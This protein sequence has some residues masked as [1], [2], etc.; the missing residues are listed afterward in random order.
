MLMDALLVDWTFK[1]NESSLRSCIGFECLDPES[2][3]GKRVDMRNSV[4]HVILQLIFPG[5]RC[6]NDVY[7]FRLTQIFLYFE[8]YYFK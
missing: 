4:Y 6:R 1:R 2:F 3:D 7:V 8:E 5:L